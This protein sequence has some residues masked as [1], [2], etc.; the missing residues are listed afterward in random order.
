MTSYR[1][2]QASAHA[3]AQ[4]SLLGVGDV[5]PVDCL[6]LVEQEAGVNVIVV[7]VPNGPAGMFTRSDDIPFV[8]V[9]ASMPLVRQRFTLAHEFGHYAL[10]HEPVVD[11]TINF[12]PSD[13]RE[14]EANQ[15]AAEFLMPRT[16]IEM[17]LA[18]NDPEYIDLEVV[19]R[20]ANFFGVSCHVT[21]FRLQEAR[22]ISADLANGFQRALERGEHKTLER[23]LHLP[24][25][26]DS[27]AALAS[28]QREVRVPAAMQKDIFDGFAA[29]LITRENAARLLRLDPQ[30]FEAL[31][32]E[33]GVVAPE[34]NDLDGG[35]HV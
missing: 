12:H 18:N 1:R 24:D 15:F 27:L 11:L 33:H 20:M 35:L 2:N 5:G 3:L 34:M 23:S 7:S 19:V 13:P 28:Q 21:I 14:V 30:A 31:A 26:A 29:G 4:R 9:N 17:W 32:N 22:R 8:M 6:R 10:K 16:A 25:Y